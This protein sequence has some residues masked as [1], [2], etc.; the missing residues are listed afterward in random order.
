MAAKDDAPGWT[1]PA[2][3]M[4]IPARAR[5][6]RGPLSCPGCGAVL[7]GLRDPSTSR[8]SP[9]ASRPS[10]SGPVRAATDGA[11]IGGR[12]EL[13]RTLGEGGM[14]VVH[15]AYDRELRRT[16]AIK[17]LK[18]SRSEKDQVSRRLRREAR[19]LARLSHPNVVTVYDTGEHEGATYLVMEL[20]RGRSLDEILPAR[21]TH[22][23]PLIEALAKVARGVAHA[24]EEGI[25][26][27]DLKPANILV[28]QEGEPKVT[29]FGLARLAETGTALT[30]SGAML[31][32]P[33]YMSPEQVEGRTKAIDARTDVYALGAILYRILAGRTPHVA[34]SVIELSQKI[35]REDP[36]PPRKIAPTTPRELET[37]ALKALEKD[38]ARRYA[39]A[40]E[41]AAE[42]ARFLAGKPIRAS[43]PSGV[44]RTVRRWSRRP[45]LVL[46]VG[47]G[48]VAL[49]IALWVALPEGDRPEEI[50]GP[51]VP[52]LG[53][54]RI[55]DENL[56]RA[57]ERVEAGRRILE[58]A[59]AYARVAKYRIE[60]LAR[61]VAQASEE[62]ERALE[63]SPEDEGAWLGIAEARAM[64]G[65]APGALAACDRAV[66]AAP[67]STAARIARGRQRLRAYEGARHEKGGRPKAETA[68]SAELRE[69][70][71]A[72]LASAE[73][74]AA[75]VR[76]RLLA[77][78]S[79]A[80]V[81]GRHEEAEEFL[82]EYLALSPDDGPAHWCRGHALSHLGRY[83]EA[84][85]E[86]SEALRCNVRDLEA[87]LSRADAL[88]RAGDPAGAAL[89]YEAVLAADPRSELALLGRGLTKNAS[90]DLRGALADL[91]AAIEI[92][93][94]FAL[95]WASR[96]GLHHS[97]GD[98]ELALSDYDR[99]VELDPG[100]AATV[101]DRAVLRRARGDLAG[102][103]ADLDS[104]L[105][106]DPE[107]ALA[108]LSRAIFRAE[109]NDAAGALDDLDEA[110]RIDPALAGARFRRAVLRHQRG[111]VTGALSDYDAF[112][113]P[114]RE[115]VLDLL[116][117]GVRSL[118]R[119]DAQG[120]LQAFEE[121]LRLSPRC[122]FAYAN[123]GVVRIQMEEH[124][125]AVAD[126]DHALEIHQE[127]SAAHEK[128]AVLLEARGESSRAAEDREKVRELAEEISSVRY[129]RGVAWFQRG[130]LERSI[131]DLTESLATLPDDVDALLFLARALARRS[132]SHGTGPEAGAKRAADVSRALDALERAVAGGL[133]DPE[134]I[135]D[136]EDLAPLSG[137]PRFQAI[138]G[139]K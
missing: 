2:C 24:H 45:A 42:L 90:G 54:R 26:H 37:I 80:F 19:A 5:S 88:L 120:G 86:M 130:D 21:P 41:F 100:D 64:A 103:A 9:G 33:L 51:P 124:D 56:E 134:G 81:R 123:R 38:P 74:S 113:V 25:V 16:V 52:G 14:A 39:D 68:E 1:C 62:F 35:A 67:G 104:A 59:R 119:D 136:D 11:V 139:G 48:L 7:P 76:E 95:A 65:D 63:D 8:E 20:V 6:G 73:T 66:A 98:L 61:I 93:P 22:Q 125:A 79:L 60:E 117:R 108:H 34:T 138:V 32:T 106:T 127:N 47:A 121:A 137:E 135:R 40:G 87:L 82:A 133:D 128:R 112:L 107:F 122:A 44:H 10:P 92:D 46:G 101:H 85:T 70:I 28:P 75:E 12:Y 71:E 91:G 3:S 96:A 94:R 30:R 131:A 109:A 15:E 36:V 105:G 58:Q 89:D 27:R 77:R 99:A 4:E 69:K 114:E 116:D 17:I 57:R 118:E 83:D 110:L 53:P 23:R 97:L 84:R 111:D 18:E 43:R 129:N 55:E 29:D 132:G 102:A 126:L 78:G 50:E 72:D 49:W 115:D 13:R 31:G